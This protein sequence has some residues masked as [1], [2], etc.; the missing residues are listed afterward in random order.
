MEEAG[1]FAGHRIFVA[2]G[3]VEGAAGNGAEVGGEREKAVIPVDDDDGLAIRHG[4]HDGTEVGQGKAR[5]EEDVADEHEVMAAARHSASQSL[6]ER[7]DRLDGNA[8]D[9]GERLLFESPDLPPEAVELAVG[10][11]DAD[12]LADWEER[13]QAHD[14]AMGVGSEGDRRRVRQVEDPRH[15]ALRRRHDVSEHL[16]PL[17]VGE[18]GGVEPALLLRREGDVGPEMM[19]VGGKMQPLRIGGDEALEVRLVAHG[20]SVVL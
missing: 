19:A 6:R 7:G 12:G 18:A 2:A 20:R 16:L 8:G 14:E 13:E 10:R 15:M 17:A 4:A 11:Q 3:H 5:V 9:S 1:A